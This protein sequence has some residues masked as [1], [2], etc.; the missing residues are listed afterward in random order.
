M[1]MQVEKYLERIGI[2]RREPPS[3]EFLA[4]L[5]EAHLRNV[6]YENCEIFFQR[7]VPSLAPEALY[8][9]IVE[10]GRGGYCFELNGAFAWLLA[11]CGFSFS[12]TFC[13]WCF[14][15][16]DPLPARRHRLLLVR[17]GRSTWLADV[18][19]CSPCPLTP[20]LLRTGV[21]QER[22]GLRF[23][24]VRDPLH[25]FI[26]QKETPEEGFLNYF[27]FWNTPHF[28]QDFLYVNYYYS[29]E[30]SSVFRNKLVVNIPAPD[31]RRRLFLDPDDPEKQTFI[32]RRERPGSPP[33]EQKFSRS[34]LRLLAS[35][36]AK[37]FF[38]TSLSP[39]AL[40]RELF[41]QEEN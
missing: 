4:R 19:I 33:E 20:L 28:T 39:D 37:H 38:K 9:K 3:A 23:R 7:R 14:N 17:L 35:L 36:L 1:A 22:N 10:R 27:S 34:D 24:I 30:A 40:F 25:G 11:E 6:P 18:G 13:R 16:P 26:V 21:I 41:S 8:D 5:Q 32:F 2:S 29:T 15:D 12:Q 31:S